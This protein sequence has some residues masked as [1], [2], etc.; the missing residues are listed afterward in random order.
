MTFS[1]SGMKNSILRVAIYIRKS[2]HDKGKAEPRLEMQRSKLPEIAQDM[3]CTSCEIY[4]DGHSSAS[5][6]NLSNLIE[7][8]RLIQDIKDGKIDVV[9]VIE[10]SRLSRDDSMT[11]FAA[12]LDLCKEHQVKLATPGRIL[13]P[14]SIGDWT[15]LAIEGTLASAE[16]K[17]TI[18]RM[19]QGAT[20]AY[21]NGKYAGGGVPAPYVL[22]KELRRPVVDPAVLPACQRLW[23][24]AENHSAK[25][26]S[27]ML[28]VP[29]ISVRRAISDKRLDYLQ[30]QRRDK[31]NGEIIK[32]EWEPVLGADQASRIR[33]ARKNRTT[34]GNNTKPSALLTGLDVLRC[35]YCG[36]TAKSWGN[37]KARKDGTT[38]RYYGCS[39]KST[40]GKCKQSR[41]IS[42]IIFDEKVIAN[43]FNTVG[44]LEDLM[45]HWLS[46]QSAEGFDAKLKALEAEE[47]EQQKSI[48]RLAL[49]VAKGTISDEQV[50]RIRSGIEGSLA[51]VRAEKAKLKSRKI[52]P[53]DWN[54]LIL[55]REEFE[56]LDFID[57]RRFIALVLDEIRL[58]S[59]YAIITYKFPRNSA[60]E[61]T[62][63]IH[64]PPSMRGTSKGLKPRIVAKRPRASK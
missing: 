26:I 14:A 59:S 28:G 56:H 22:G 37:A 46:S 15:L 44:C 17:K 35:G 40:A 30:A 60:G 11:D 36:K 31:E 42:L 38:L 43:V 55:T 32:C 7:R 62:A 64:L 18:E 63:R 3:G 47:R 20:E 54:S 9:L 33:S 24:L 50:V 49:A 2:R 25:A 4:D 21:L 13:D 27:E 1:L 51:I 61:R 45:A 10:I 29:H 5:K 23:R 48:D 34:N 58:Y 16:M 53:P 57:Q 6:K 39:S 41:M 12:L 19:A 8:N 52:T